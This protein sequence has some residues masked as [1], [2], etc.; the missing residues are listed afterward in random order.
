VAGPLLIVASVVAV[1]HWMV[2]SGRLTTQHPDL[3][4]FWTPTYCLL[5]K[6]LAAGHV[7]GWNPFVMGGVPFAADPQ[8]GWMYVPA[9]VLFSALPCAMA[10]RL[11]VV[12]QPILAGL[13]VY[14]FTCSEGVSR[15]GAT[16]GGVALALGLSASRLG[17]FLPFPSY[18][19]WTALLLAAC[20]R[21]FASRTWSGRLIWTLITAATWGQ[22]AA[23]H[24]AQGLLSGTAALAI[25]VTVKSW[26]VVRER[27]WQ[28]RELIGG[29]AVLAAALPL[30]SLAFLLPR[31]IYLPHTSFKIGS[32]VFEQA[33]SL[34]A[35]WP[36]RLATSPGFFLGATP[37]VLSVGSLWAWR[38]TPFR[39]LIAAFA[40]FGLLSYLAGSA[41]VVR[42]ITPLSRRVGIVGLYSHFPARFSMGMLLAIP[43]LAAVGLDAWRDSPS[44]RPRVLMLVPGLLVWFV[45]TSA[46][47]A[48]LAQLAI[49]GIG[50]LLG[51]SALLSVA[52]RPA[53]AVFVPLV[54][55]AE[56]VANGLAGQ[57]A[58]SVGLG[59]AARLDPF[60]ADA[61]GW[62]SALRAPDVDVA[63]Y[64]R[65]GPLAR[66]LQALGGGARYL[67]LD[68]A[69]ADHRGYLNHLSPRYW[70]LMANQ[71]S[72][73]FSLRDAQG[74]NPVQLERYWTYV[75]AVSQAVRLDYTAAVL[76]RP[77]STALD[78]LQV[79]WVVGPTT[80]PPLSGLIPS[81]TDGPWTLY[82][83]SDQPP[84][85]AL[86]SSWQAVLS[87]EQ[88]LNA[89]TSPA[90]DPSATAVVEG[91]ALPQPGSPGGGTA[92]YRDLGSQAARVLVR[93]SAPSLVVVHNSFDPGW[94]ARLDGRP[95]PILH[96]DYLVQG[97]MVPAG[98]H[99]LDLSY[100]DPWI[101][102][103]AAG[104]T[105]AVMLLAGVAAL[106]RKKERSSLAKRQGPVT[107]ARSGR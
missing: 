47:G 101:G 21:F 45:L 104:S 16:I 105:V 42:L 2:F 82:R 91:S 23:A 17:V 44:W 74:Y 3:L 107:A 87:P 11:M 103:G 27:R 57:S 59:A 19:A 99:T 86:L 9:M 81:F 63:S 97:V 6:S 34:P 36:L 83:R 22:L 46:L 89:V 30:V 54:V 13:G 4:A 12:L 95:V 73:L 93:A 5:G 60:G 85:A 20:S 78:L 48:S 62:F 94:H 100:D 7:P 32:A 37:L 90:F 51:G 56:L 15:A 28:G 8:S 88:A 80:A 1:L 41:P 14:W 96:A 39:P 77:S 71:R 102:Y 72:M 68:P 52:R 43:V 24:F 58:D 50:L 31:L 92:S 67:S 40:A 33:T 64:L 29:L 70:E 66:E 25:Y 35:A 38:A 98:D 26:S 18:L 49:P 69:A 53:L 79:G 75:R 84:R 10:I 61:S 55:V 76:E 106:A 65:P